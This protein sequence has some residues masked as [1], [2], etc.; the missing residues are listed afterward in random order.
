MFGSHGLEADDGT[1]IGMARA[2][3]LGRDGLVREI[4]QIAALVP[5]LRVEHKPYG[6]ALHFRGIDPA[7]MEPVLQSVRQLRR[8]RPEV[9]LKPGK[10]VIE[11]SV[12]P[13][14]KAFAIDTLQHQWVPD[15]TIY[16]GDDRTDEDVFTAMWPG[17]IGIKVGGGPSAAAYRVSDPEQLERLLWRLADRRGRVVAGWPVRST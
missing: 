7:G 14:C 12:L 17:D 1:T 10:C 5:G 8:G 2:M 4:E 13:L 11:L 16:A 3:S 6:A 15:V 9:F